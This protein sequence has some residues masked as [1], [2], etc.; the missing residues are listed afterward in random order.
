[1]SSSAQ[2][3]PRLHIPYFVGAGHQVAKP[4]VQS[5]TDLQQAQVGRV[6]LSSAEVIDFLGGHASVKGDR[7]LRHT[8]VFCDY[9]LDRL[10]ERS[11]IWTEGFGLSFGWH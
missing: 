3:L 1:M 5:I 6:A 9:G 7:I 2:F 8:L 10:R 11:V 4:N